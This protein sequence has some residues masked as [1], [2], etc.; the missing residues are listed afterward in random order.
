MNSSIPISRIFDSQLTVNE[1]TIAKPR[2]FP[3]SP[4][5]VK[6]PEGP[7]L[8]LWTFVP[9][10]GPFLQLATEGVFGHFSSV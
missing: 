1:N 5:I 3:G 7:T 10:L 8:S 6:H 2:I 4:Q 9:Y